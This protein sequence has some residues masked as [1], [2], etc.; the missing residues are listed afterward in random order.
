MKVLVT[1]ANGLLGHHVLMQ[2]I[3]LQHEVNIVVRSTQHIY[4]D[5]SSLRVFDGKFTD[6]EILK[7]AAIGCDAIIHIAAVT[8]TD[9]L[10]YKDYF[11]VNVEGSS[12]VIRV[13][14]ELN[15]NTLIF[16]SSANTIGYG[17]FDRPAD[18]TLSIQ[19]PF[20]GSY[21]ARSKAEAER[22]FSEAAERPG[23]HV[24]MVNPTFMIGAYDTKP[25]SGK[26][27]LKGYRKRLLFVPEGGKNFV[28]AIDV[29][30]AVCNA[31]TMGRNGERYLA[32]GVD[33]S[34][35]QFYKLQSKVGGYFQIVFILPNCFLKCIGKLGDLFRFFGVRTEICSMN[36]KQLMIQEYY[37]NRKVVNEL[38][39]HQTS[40]EVAIVDAISWLRY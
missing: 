4:F 32:A 26:L 33:L 20:S 7:T 16:I 18:E 19:I 37:S 31:L 1:G 36:L 24:I 10:Y 22:L 23:R 14:N 28:A 39:M 3:E 27:M 9:L 35:K 2:L 12:T 15:I 40:I 11:Q 34:F 17:T 30:T 21:Y 8:A 38:Q 25:S 5:L 29:A 6:F 13:A